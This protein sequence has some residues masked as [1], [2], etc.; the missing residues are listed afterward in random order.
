MDKSKR[1]HI[2]DILE[3]HC[4][5]HI[6]P[7]DKMSFPKEVDS[8]FYLCWQ[9]LHNEIYESE[10]L[11]VYTDTLDCVLIYTSKFKVNT[12]TILEYRPNKSQGIESRKSMKIQS[13]NILGTNTTK[14]RMDQ[15]FNESQA[16]LNEKPDD[17]R[18]SVGVQRMSMLKH[19]QSDKSAKSFKSV[20][21]IKSVKTPD[22]N[23]MIRKSDLFGEAKLKEGIYIALISQCQ[24]HV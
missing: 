22:L 19:Q 8:H 5:D 3:G 4:D 13:N 17:K 10:V 16:P 18:N 20:M 7:L 11:K 6:V 15:L 12:M 2:R 23:P 21:S 9:N 14:V 1:K 24:I